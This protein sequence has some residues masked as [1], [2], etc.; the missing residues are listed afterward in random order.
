MI[1]L[2][3]VSPPWLLAFWDKIKDYDIFYGWKC[4]GLLYQQLCRF[5]KEHFTRMVRRGNIRYDRAIEAGAI[6]TNDVQYE[7]S[8]PFNYLF[9]VATTMEVEGGAEH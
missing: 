9:Y 3:A 6:N 1:M 8:R 4:W 7:P 5:L 2:L